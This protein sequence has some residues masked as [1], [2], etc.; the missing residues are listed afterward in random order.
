MSK[1]AYIIAAS[2]L[3][4]SLSSGQETRE[5]YDFNFDGHPD[6]RSKTL[7]DGKADQYDVYLFN[8]ETKSFERD[9][10]LAGAINPK[11]DEE[12]K[13]VRCIFPGGHSGA[14]YNGTVFN[15]DGKSFKFAYSVRQTDITIDGKIV[16]V[17][18]KAKLENGAPVIQSIERIKPHW[19]E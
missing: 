8:P 1:I 13:Q 4:G 17:C 10:V 14:I 16:Y 11:P 12:H 15:W 5:E 19:E 9:P 3:A 2:L 7:E 18:V 6:F